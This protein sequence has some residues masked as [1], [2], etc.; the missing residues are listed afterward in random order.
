MTILILEDEGLAAERAANLL[1]EYDKNIEITIV[2][3][4]QEAFS[5]L[6]ENPAPD[7]ILSDIQL[8]DGL[9][10][11]L[12]S[13]LQISCPVIFMTAYQQY[14]IDAFKVYAID[15]LLKPIDKED[16]FRALKKYKTLT[17]ET[18]KINSLNEQFSAY[19]KQLT[20]N[21]LYKS[22]FLVK[23]GSTILFKNINEVAYF[24]A[25]DKIVYLV[26]RDG[27]HFI[28]DYRLEELENHLD[29]I[30]FFR[31]NRKFF[32]NI[33]A[34]AKVKMLA[35]SRLEVFLNPAFSQEIFISREKLGIFKAWLDK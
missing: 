9:S 27:K 23:T 11:D 26:A 6:N 31:I 5:F 32:V 30:A 8:G 25:D 33:D 10:F 14:A 19:Y 21:Q 15:Y 2:D 3:S 13:R 18:N 28:I 35:N 12:F 7:L 4:C 16:L 1:A 22:R 20:N 34:I 24:F 17:V 29:P